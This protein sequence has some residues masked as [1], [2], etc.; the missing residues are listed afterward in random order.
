MARSK[1]WLKL[2]TEVLRDPKLVGRSMTER[3]MWLHLLCV[4]Q[5]CNADGRL[6]NGA[7]YP[8]SI[9]DI[10]RQMFVQ[11]RS[12]IA[13]LR[14]LI[15]YMVTQKSLHWDGDTL[16]L[17]NFKRRQEI[18]PSDTPEAARQRQREHRAR[19]KQVSHTNVVTPTHEEQDITNKASHT[20]SV[21]TLV[22]PLNNI[23]NKYIYTS[24][25]PSPSRDKSVTESTQNEAGVYIRERVVRAQPAKLSREKCDHAESLWEKAL[26]VIKERVN[27]LNFNAWFDGSVGVSLEQDTVL[28]EAKSE[29]AANYLNSNQRSLAAN[30][31]SQVSGQPLQVYFH[32]R[33][34][35]L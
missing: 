6:I 21:T 8:L 34:E 11:D 2:W 27:G 32:A 23:S 3:G 14:R 13:S 26:S 4:A 24:P 25:H 28:V 20:N 16:V 10:A 17:D 31:V 30:V 33:G 12:E 9:T 15:D 5:E 1:P 19:L 35:S 22:N 29:Y 7:G 18:A